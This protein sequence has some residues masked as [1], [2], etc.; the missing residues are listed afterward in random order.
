M[1][2]NYRNARKLQFAC[3]DVAYFTHNKFKVVGRTGDATM[4]W[5][6]IKFTQFSTLIHQTCD[7]TYFVH[8]GTNNVNVP[9]KA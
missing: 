6:E 7:A 9:S 2:C 8:Q 1:L 5:S 4:E 3:T